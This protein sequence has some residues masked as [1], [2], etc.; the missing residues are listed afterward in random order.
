MTLFFPTW[1]ETPSSP[2]FAVAGMLHFQHLHCWLSLH[3]CKRKT[4]EHSGKYFQNLDDALLN[5]L[6]SIWHTFSEP[7]QISGEIWLFSSQF[8]NK[9][10]SKKG[11][12]SWY[13]RT[14][15]MRKVVFLLILSVLH[16]LSRYIMGKKEKGKLM[17]AYLSIYHEWKQRILNRERV[18]QQYNQSLGCIS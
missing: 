10:S 15:V 12:W 7:A 1:P 17:G 14:N 5:V 4:S 11:I 18:I 8:Q 3:N 2:S 6:Y 16:I 13:I 9:S